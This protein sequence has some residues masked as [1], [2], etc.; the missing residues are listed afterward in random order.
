MNILKVATFL[1]VA[2]SQT[3]SV[4]SKQPLKF[5]DPVHPCKKKWNPDTAP[6]NVVH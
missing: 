6:K 5:I 1:F 3:N 4:Q 2:S